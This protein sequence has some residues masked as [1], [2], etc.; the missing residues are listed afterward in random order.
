[1]IALGSEARVFVA[2]RPV[3]FWMGINGTVAMAA[4]GLQGD[5]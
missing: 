2:T 1:M 3:D 4:E 5:P